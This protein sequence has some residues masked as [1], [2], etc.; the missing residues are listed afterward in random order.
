MDLSGAPIG[1]EVEIRHW[2]R[3]LPRDKLEEMVVESLKA[4]QEGKQGAHLQSNPDSILRRQTTSQALLANYMALERGKNAFAAPQIPKYEHLV[5]ADHK[6]FLEYDRDCPL[7]RQRI[8]KTETA[9]GEL[10]AH[11]SRLVH[12][13]RKYC[14]KGYKHVNYGRGFF[15]LWQTLSE[16]EWRG[17]MGAVAPLI[18]SVGETLEELESMHEG[19]LSALE[20]AFSDHLGEFIDKEISTVTNFRHAYQHT[21]DELE[22]ALALHL[23]GCGSNEE[24][25]ARSRD[26]V[27]KRVA[28]ELARFDLIGELNAQASRKRLQ[29]CDRVCSAVYG[30][31]GYHHTCHS[32]LA[33]LETGI[34][35]LSHTA[36]QA[37]KLIEKEELLRSGKRSQLERDLKKSGGILK[38]D[39]PTS[40][41]PG[42]GGTGTGTDDE[43][44]SSTRSKMSRSYSYTRR[45]L[46][47]DVTGSEEDFSTINAPSSPTSP[48]SS[49]RSNSFSNLADCDDIHEFPGAYS[50]SSAGPSPT[51]T[52][53]DTV[54]QG[55][56]WKKSTK[57]TWQR[58]WFYVRDGRMFYTR[59]QQWAWSQQVQAPSLGQCTP[60]L[61]QRD[62]K[63]TAEPEEETEVLVSEFM[64]SSV[65]RAPEDETGRRFTFRLFSPKFRKYLLQAETEDDYERWVTTIE[66]EIERSL[67]TS[68]VG[69]MSATSLEIDVDAIEAE[70]GGFGGRNRMDDQDSC[71]IGRATDVDSL[72]MRDRLRVTS[73]EG[74]DKC[75]DCGTTSPDWACSNLGILVCIACSGVHRS[76]GVHVSKVR[77]LNLD[78]WSSATLGVM[79]S[80]G[81]ARANAIYDPQGAPERGNIRTYIERKYMERAFVQGGEEEGQEGSNRRLYDAA[82]AGDVCGV[83]RAMAQGAHVNGA[84]AAYGNRTALHAAT[85]SAQVQCVE[86]LCQN[87]A[88]VD[89]KC[90]LGKTPLEYA[91][92]LLRSKEKAA[93]TATATAA[94]AGADDGPSATGATTTTAPTTVTAVTEEKPRSR[95]SGQVDEVIDIL[96][97]KLQRDVIGSSGV[98]GTR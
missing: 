63:E 25:L 49:S 45:S 91:A 4:A 13:C 41:P 85:L 33:V 47:V 34:S 81:N 22:T 12:E 98:W 3:K 57:H 97:H 55:Y 6:S 7:V 18:A 79:T 96:V 90:S 61:F 29:L 36:T 68:L 5:A 95:S 58:R 37:R 19:M 67:T 84:L 32:T 51:P 1:D 35:G 56:L 8:V 87:D 60:G 39:K 64:L 93:A 65:K 75:A 71:D 94:G 23:Q 26:V 30:F 62:E 24:R 2:V 17:R 76:L 70:F 88:H 48:G 14:E 89:I 15:A 69:Q 59:E 86:L 9:V 77:S 21:A 31:L 80:I 74:N 50:H 10:R 11:M 92:E 72:S 78:M 40:P 53:A 16:E 42:S 46:S 66:S 38:Q 27:D 54:L 52:P 73:T 20:A 28:Y 44:P 83:L 82:A 43:R